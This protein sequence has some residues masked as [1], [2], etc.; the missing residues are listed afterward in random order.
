MS[1]NYQYNTIEE[2]L[3]DLKKGKIVLVTDDPDR[4]NEGD[5]ICAAEFA[6]RENINFMAT[7][8]KGLICT[9]MSAEL[10]ARLNFPPMVAENTDNHSTAFTVAVDHVD[11]T[12]GISAAERSYTIMKC[13]DDQSKPEDFRRPGHVFPLISRKGGVLVRNGHTE[14]TTDLMR[15]AGLKECGVC[16]EVMKEDGTMMVHHSYG[17]WQKSITLHLLRS[18]ICRII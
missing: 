8:A 10:A 3:R 4:E 14:A 18:V 16:C 17:K 1:Q 7:Y 12:T 5:L 2:A 11:T 15:L 9:P 13:V 6:T